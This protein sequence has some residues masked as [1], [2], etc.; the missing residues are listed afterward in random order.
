MGDTVHNGSDGRGER[1]RF[2]VGN[3]IAKGN[4]VNRQMMEI[5]KSLLESKLANPEVVHTVFNELVRKALGDGGESPPDLA[6]MKLYFELIVG[7]TPLAVELSGPDGEPIG[8]DLARVRVAILAALADEPSARFKVA[9]ALLSLEVGG[10]GD[11]TAG[12]DGPG[13]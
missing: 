2:A 3:R 5:R 13:A 7:K 10:T 9:R 11:G 8:G 6:A 4:T 1:G 12:D